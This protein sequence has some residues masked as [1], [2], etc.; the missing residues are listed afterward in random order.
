MVNK[1][2]TLS[3]FKNVSEEY[4]TLWQSGSFM[5]ISGPAAKKVWDQWKAGREQ[6]EVMLVVVHDELEKE[7]GKVTVKTDGHSSAK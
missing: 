2:F 1:R 6:G 7:L 3:G 4:P 5:N